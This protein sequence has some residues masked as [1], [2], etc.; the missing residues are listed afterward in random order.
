[1]KNKLKII[2][3]FL[4]IISYS[5]SDENLL[6]KEEKLTK[7]KLIEHLNKRNNNYIFH[8]ESTFLLSKTKTKLPEPI[9]FDNIEEMDDFLNQMES[10]TNGTS[11][12]AVLTHAPPNDGG[13]GDS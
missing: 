3:L 5:C 12:S 13:A 1:M 6:L 2:I 8:D 4:T 9:Y 11:N 7:E 10:L